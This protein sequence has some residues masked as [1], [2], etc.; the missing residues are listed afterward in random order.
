MILANTR[1]SGFARFGRFVPAIGWAGVIFWSSTQSQIP[2]VPPLVMGSDK[3][4]HACVYAVLSGLLLW[5]AKSRQLGA[6]L[7]WVA[8][9]SLYGASDEVHQIWVP[10]RTADVLDWLA[11]TAGAL[12]AAAVWLRLKLAK[13]LVSASVATDQR[14]R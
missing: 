3:V 7:V 5:A 10:Q 11:D 4:V 8:L 12:L 9:A 2:F 14:S 1:C 6:A 13:R